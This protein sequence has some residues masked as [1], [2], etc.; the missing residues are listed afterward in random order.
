MK[1]YIQR[2]G[3][4]DRVNHWIVAFCF[5]LLGLTGLAFFHPAF[6]FLSNALGGPVWSRILH[7][8][9]GIVMA[10]SFVGLARRVRHENIIKPVDIE[11]LKRIREVINNEDGPDSLPIGKYNAGQKLMFWTMVGSVALLLISGIVIWRSYFAMYFPIPVI[12]FAMVIHMLAGFTGIVALIV[13]V[14]AAIW[15]K[16]TIRAMTRGSVEEAWAKHHH[17][18]WFKEQTGAK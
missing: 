15:V 6:F 9:L 3:T 4:S 8:F 1:K 17:P 5:V 11:W 2:Y 7:P 10:I 18:E 14:Y 13:H 12:R 16:G